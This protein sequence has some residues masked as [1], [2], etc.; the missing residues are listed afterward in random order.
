MHDVAAREAYDERA[1]DL[2]EKNDE[3]RELHLSELDI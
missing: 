1:K 3:A 2:A